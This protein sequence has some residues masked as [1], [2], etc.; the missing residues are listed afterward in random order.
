VERAVAEEEGGVGEEAAPR[1]AYERGADEERG[2]VRGEEEEDLADE[3]VYQ[4]RRRL[5]GCCLC[6]GC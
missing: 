3:V 6:D 1:L 4:P 2:V 5:H